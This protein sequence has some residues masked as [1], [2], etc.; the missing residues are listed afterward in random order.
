MKPNNNTTVECR[1]IR[2]PLVPEIITPRVFDSLNAGRYEGTEATEVEKLLMKGDRVL[3]LGAGLGFISSLCAMSKKP[4]AVLSYEADPRLVPYIRQV[5][6]LNGVEHVEVRNALLTTSA[7][8]GPY[9]SFYIREDFWG[10]SLDAKQSP[11][12]ETAKVPFESFNRVVE[13]FRPTFV[14]SDIEGGELDLF[15]HA[16][17]SGV[18]RVL[19]EIHSRVIGRRGVKRLFDAMSARDFHYD[20]FHSHKSVVLF[21]HVAR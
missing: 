19:M 14:I 12:I 17:L 7:S 21:S 9:G 20:Q 1:G 18:T 8:P 13:E 4:E 15:L 5:H 16:N 2:F 6:A 3:E 10:S 11:Y